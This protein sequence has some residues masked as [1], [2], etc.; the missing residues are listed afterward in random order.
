M[1]K[2]Q[3]VDKELEEIEVW[4]LG[5]AEKCHKTRMLLQQEEGVSTQSKGQRPLTDA[6]L[7]KVSADRRKRIF[8][9][10]FHQ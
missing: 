4:A 2:S 3:L 1:S 10:R 7:A 8:K 9:G 5:L 6:Q